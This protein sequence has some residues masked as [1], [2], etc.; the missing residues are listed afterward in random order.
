MVIRRQRWSKAGSIQ[1]LNLK[2]SGWKRELLFRTIALV[3]EAKI[4]VTPQWLA[5]IS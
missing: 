2:K 5:S 3:V 4:C 1:D